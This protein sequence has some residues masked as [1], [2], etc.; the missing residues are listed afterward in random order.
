MLDATLTAEAE[1]RLEMNSPPICPDYFQLAITLK[2]SSEFNSFET[3]QSLILG[4]EHFH[5]HVPAVI[6]NYKQKIGCPQIV[7]GVICPHKSACT[8]S[9]PLSA[10]NLTLEEKVFYVVSQEHT[11]YIL[12]LPL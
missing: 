6:I 5:P 12:S 11:H 2:F 7:L 4:L 8:S 1:N 9:K 10:C 3:L